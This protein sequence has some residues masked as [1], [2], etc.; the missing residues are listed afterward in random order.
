MLKIEINTSNHSKQK[1]QCCHKIKL[2]ICEREK[3]RG[4]KEVKKARGERG[5]EEEAYIGFT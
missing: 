1:I 4:E 2:R 3:K 5:R